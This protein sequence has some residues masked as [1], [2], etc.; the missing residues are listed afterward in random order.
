MYLCHT[1][2]ELGATPLEAVLEDLRAFLVTHPAEVLVVVNQDAITPADFV[3]A[4]GEAGLARYAI[5][6]PAPG[7][8]WPTLG[9]L[10]AQDRRLLVVAENA[11]GGAPWYRLAY[12][13]LVQET[14]FEFPSTAS[15]DPAGGPPGELRAQPGTRRR[16]AVPDEPLGQHRPGPAA[17]QRH[18]GQRL[19]PAAGAA[20]AR[21]SRS[22]GRR[23]NLLAVDFYL[24]GDLFRVA[25]TLNGG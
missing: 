25:T 4:V 14:P 8:P 3:A 17:E 16:A 11:A 20:P 9:E 19:R 15:L 21:A 13:R 12:D 5:T 23:V 2:C 10:V 1:F 6:P 7:S 24:H 18:R 22:A